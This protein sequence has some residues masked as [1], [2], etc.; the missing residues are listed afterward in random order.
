MRAFLLISHGP[1][2]PSMKE[3]VQMIAGE[4]DNLFAASLNFDDSPE[5]FGEKLAA[6]EP[7]LAAYDD[8]VIFTD[9][10]GGSP[11]NTAITR[12]MNDPKKTLISGM[13]FPMILTAL[14]EEGAEIPYLMETGRQGILDIRTMLASMSDDED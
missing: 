1:L 8:V 6:L 7:A 12:Y 3:S 4:H 10:Y 11:G 9:L 13:N 5:S 2:A 14:L